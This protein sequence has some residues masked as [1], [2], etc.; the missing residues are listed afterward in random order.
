MT[1][2]V[3]IGEFTET[4]K[5]ILCKWH[6]TLRKLDSIDGNKAKF[7]KFIRTQIIPSNRVCDVATKLN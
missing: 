3:F 7:N 1:S 5:H 4:G 6:G 2:A